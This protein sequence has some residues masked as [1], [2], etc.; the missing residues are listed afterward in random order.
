MFFPPKKT[1]AFHAALLVAVMIGSADA[2]QSDFDRR[3]AAMQQART[4][5]VQPAARVA[6]ADTGMDYSAPPAPTQ[7]QVMPAGRNVNR[8]AAAPRRVLTQATQR[9]SGGIRVAQA[10]SQTGRTSVQTRQ[11]RVGSNQVRSYLPQHMRTAQ[12]PGTTMLDGGAPIV[13]SNSVVGATTVVQGPIVGDIVGGEII[14]GCSSCSSGCDSCIGTSYLE[15]PCCERGGCPPGVP[16]WLDRFG[17]VLSNGEYFAGAT[18]FSQHPVHDPRLDSGGLSDDCSH[19]FY[20]GFNFGLPLCEISCGVFSGQ[21]GLRA[22]QTNFDGNEFTAEDREQLFVTAGFYRRVDYG[23]QM[24]IV[25]DILHEEW[26]TEVDL[27]QLR[28]EFGWVYP[29]GSTLGFR[30]AT[31]LQ[32]DVNSGLFNG[33]AFTNL[34]HATDDNYRFFWRYDAPNGGYGDNVRWV[35]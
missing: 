9:Q 26:F 6:S 10:A 13:S 5:G 1:I 11:A 17:P 25:W 33:V 28:G 8:V 16:C 15:D 27:V 35:V 30:Y 4:R 18:S 24:G 23:L 14:D 29:S 12:L 21:V 19:G 22:T 20:Q 32:D 7:N 34:I 2:Q 31:N 3:L